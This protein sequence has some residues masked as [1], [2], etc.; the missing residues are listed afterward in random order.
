[1]IPWSKLFISLDSQKEFQCVV[2]FSCRVLQY[3][4]SIHFINSNLNGL[5]ISDVTE[6]MKELGLGGKLRIDIENPTFGPCKSVIT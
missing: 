5:T 1:M 4:C 6:L 2:L 3:I